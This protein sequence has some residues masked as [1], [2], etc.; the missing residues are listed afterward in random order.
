V[1]SFTGGDKLRAKLAELAAKVGRPATVQVGFLEGATYP[2]GTSVAL[3]AAVQEFG[4]PSRGIPP[5][6]FFRAMIAKESGHWGDDVGKILAAN[7]YDGPK[8]LALMGEEI[9]GELRQS[10]VETNSPPLAPATAKA[11]GSDKPL[12]DTGHMLNSIDYEVT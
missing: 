2:N 8:A 12:V 10:I 6:P 5:R 7:G 1:A 11:K 4:A 3:V 9:S